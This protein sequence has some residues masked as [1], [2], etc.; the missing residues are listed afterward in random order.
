MIPGIILG[1]A[2][3]LY[4]SFFILY[5][6]QGWEFF[7]FLFFLNLNLREKNLKYVFSFQKIQSYSVLKGL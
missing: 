7:L 3:V 2:P 1:F 5:L 4:L 6:H